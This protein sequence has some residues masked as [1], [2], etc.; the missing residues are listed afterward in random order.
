MARG[1]AGITKVPSDQSVMMTQDAQRCLGRFLL[2]KGVEPK[3]AVS[4]LDSLQKYQVAHNTKAS[5][6][7]EPELLKISPVLSSSFAEKLRD[8]EAHDAL[9]TQATTDKEHNFKLQVLL[10]TRLQSLICKSLSLMFLMLSLAGCGLKTLPKADI[11]DLRPEIPFRRSVSSAD[12]IHGTKTA[13]KGTDSKKI[14]PVSASLS[15][16]KPKEKTP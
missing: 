5:A 9:S 10:S 16:P 15:T 8:L 14:T 11:E 6:L 7:I 1:F 3:R 2:S 13:T 12:T 4:A